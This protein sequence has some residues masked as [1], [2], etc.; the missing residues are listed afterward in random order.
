[1]SDPKRQQIAERARFLCEYCHYPEDASLISHQIDHVIPKQHGGGDELD[2]LAFACALCN[3]TK[4]PNLASLDPN[5]KEVALLYNP[6][7]QTWAEHFRLEAERIIGLTPTGRAT[8]NLLRL[9]DAARLLERRLLLQ[10]GL[11]P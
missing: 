4:G 5:T 1:M 10:R 3:R 7:T 11:Y 6:R 2:N 9:N 8:T